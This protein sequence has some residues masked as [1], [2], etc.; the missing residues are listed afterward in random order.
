MGTAHN[1]VRRFLAKAPEGQYARRARELM[2]A[3]TAM[4]RGYRDDYGALG[5]KLYIL[6]YSLPRVLELLEL[7]A[8]DKPGEFLKRE[9]DLDKLLRPYWTNFPQ[10]QLAAAAGI[11]RLVEDLKRRP[12]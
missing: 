3:L 2:T 4:V 11:A 8:N 1:V 6:E 12:V 10:D 5:E 7:L 9:P